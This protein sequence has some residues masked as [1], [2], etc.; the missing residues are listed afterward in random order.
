MD[1]LW[2]ALSRW[3]S[4]VNTTFLGFGI[5]MYQASDVHASINMYQAL[6]YESAR[7]PNALYPDSTSQR[8]P[9]LLFQSKWPPLAISSAPTVL[10]FVPWPAALRS[11]R[12]DGPER[13][14]SR[15]VRLQVREGLLEPVRVEYARHLL[16]ARA[17]V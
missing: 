10:L 9:Q 5:Y 1:W 15:D 6:F 16:W 12:S 17:R 4:A 8:D 2:I 7:R 11:H 14:V 13:R 3:T